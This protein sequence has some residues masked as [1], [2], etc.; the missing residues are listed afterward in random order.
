MLFNVE[1]NKFEECFFRKVERD[2]IYNYRAK[3]GW[4]FDWLKPITQSFEVYAII[5]ATT[6][7]L[8]EGLI[9]VKA[10]FDKDFLCVDIDIVESSPNNRKVVNGNLNKNRKYTEVGKCLIAFA[11]AYSVFVG[12]DGYVQLT[13]KTSKFE[14]YKELGAKNTSG[15]AMMFYGKDA[16]ILIEKHLHGGIKW[17]K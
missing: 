1:T 14:Y 16:K 17:L 2:E 4:T 10:N 13:S 12:L 3:N 11:C 9:A 15:Q 8:I 7:E 5:S 6:P